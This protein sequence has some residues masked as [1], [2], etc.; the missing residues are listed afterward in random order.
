MCISTTGATNLA[1]TIWT[2]SLNDMQRIEQLFGERLP[3]LRLRE[4][5]VNLRTPKRMG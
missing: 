4:N 3:W 2:R 5:A 1:M